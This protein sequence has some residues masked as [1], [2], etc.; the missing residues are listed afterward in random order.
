MRAPDRRRSAAATDTGVVTWRKDVRVFRPYP[1]EVPWSLFEDAGADT[2]TLAAV[3]DLDLVRVA[4]REG[5]VVGAYGI[6]PLGPTRYELV[7]LAVDPACRRNGLG[8]W[9]LGH[10]IGLAES[11]GA[12]EIFAACDAGSRLLARAGFERCTGGRM[13]RLEPE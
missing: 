9:L 1:D 12:R 6:R 10:A 4:K 7:V 13:L 3:H 11:R 2:E 8:R 5:T